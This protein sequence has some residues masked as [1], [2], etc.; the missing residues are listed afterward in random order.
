[1]A[2]LLT[3]GTTV[4]DSEEAEALVCWKAMEFVVDAGFSE[5]FVEG[6]NVT[7]H[8]SNFISSCQFILA[9]TDI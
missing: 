4:L 1:M 3:N 6:D 2:A 5:I 8:E 9:R 7:C